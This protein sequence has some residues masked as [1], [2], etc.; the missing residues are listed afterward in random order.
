[1]RLGVALVLAGCLPVGHAASA[2]GRL[3]ISGTVQAS[4][5]VEAKGEGYAST[6][7]GAGNLQVTVHPGPIAVRVMKANSGS[8]TYSLVLRRGQ[9]ELRIRALQYDNIITAVV[10][11]SQSDL[12]VTLNVI[13]D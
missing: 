8:R 9:E 13:P 12:A 10:P 7:Q 1:M 11:D 3:Q 2:T 6:V 4:Y 5:N